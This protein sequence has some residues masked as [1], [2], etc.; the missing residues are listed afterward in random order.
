MDPSTSAAAQ[1]LP[2][3]PAPLRRDSGNKFTRPGDKERYEYEKA[4][5]ANKGKWYKEKFHQLREKY[6]QVTATNEHYHRDL[7]LATARTKALQAEMDLLL[8]AM[9][10]A[11]PSEP[12]LAQLYNAPLP[13]AC[14]SPSFEL[15]TQ[16]AFPDVPPLQL[17]TTTSANANGYQQVHTNGHAER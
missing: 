8:D 1:P 4:K 5:A 3:R 7:S 10:I 17:D 12:A 16:A 6:D 15:H 2:I 13:P 11:L 9:S 14:D